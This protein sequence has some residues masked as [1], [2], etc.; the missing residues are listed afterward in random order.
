MQPQRATTEGPSPQLPQIWIGYLLAFATV[1]AETIAISVHPGLAKGNTAPPL[2]F[3]LADFI[4]A[5]YWFVCIYRY[6]QVMAHVPGW[7]HP[8]SPAKAVGFHFIP[9]YNIYWIFKWPQP[10]AAFVNARLGRP[11]DKPLMRPQGIGFA[12]LSALIIRVFVDPGLGLILLFMSA[13]YLSACLRRALS[14]PI[15]WQAAAGP[16]P[17]S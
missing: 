6:H 7:R 12:V 17:L 5:V 16:P 14:E 3:F 1:V 11:P 9:F 13:S 8:I 10:I 15:P 2:Y 4:A